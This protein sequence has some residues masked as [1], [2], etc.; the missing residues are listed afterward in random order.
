MRLLGFFENFVDGDMSQTCIGIDMS[1]LGEHLVPDEG[2][3][4][5]ALNVGM[6]RSGAIGDSLQ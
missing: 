6:T 3:A 4:E 1:N 5:Q 2:A